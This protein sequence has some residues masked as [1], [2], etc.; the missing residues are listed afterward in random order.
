MSNKVKKAFPVLYVLR[1]KHSNGRVRCELLKD[2]IVLSA[3]REIVYNIL[4]GHLHIPEPERLQLQKHK[5]VL[6][7]IVDK[8]KGKDQVYK[9][10]A[11]QRGGSLLG[12]LL[13]VAVPVLEVL[14]SNKN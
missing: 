5:V 9:A 13:A 10:L 12:T 7:K 1:D 2:P 8:S 6:T 11:N 3:L 4:Q 14:L